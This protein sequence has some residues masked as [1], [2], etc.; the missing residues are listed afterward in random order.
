MVGRWRYG[1][2][3]NA[4]ANCVARKYE[5]HAVFVF[6]VVGGRDENWVSR[7]L[8]GT[9]TRHTEKE[10]EKGQKTE[11]VNNKN[12]FLGSGRHTTTAVPNAHTHMANDGERQT[13]IPDM[14]CIFDVQIVLI[15]TILVSSHCCLHDTVGLAHRPRHTDA[16]RHFGIGE[17]EAIYVCLVARLF[18]QRKSIPLGTHSAPTKT[19]LRV[20]EHVNR[21]Y[22]L[23]LLEYA[24]ITCT[25]LRVCVVGR[26]RIAVVATVPHKRALTSKWK[27]NHDSLGG[28]VLLI[29]LCS[30]L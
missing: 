10:N 30:W 23:F 18:F 29:N 7:S 26:G 4:W 6:V 22:K 20:H 14:K 9:H 11:N 12:N 8:K 19:C 28:V 13:P 1:T 3:W 25:R 24:M 16:R 15:K 2:W 17:C 27:L 21:N 5:A